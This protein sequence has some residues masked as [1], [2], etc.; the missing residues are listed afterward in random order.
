MRADANVNEHLE[1]SRFTD[2]PQQQFCGPRV[3][4]SANGVSMHDR[5]ETGLVIRVTGGDI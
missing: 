2:Y 3:F 4:L 1:I 5:V